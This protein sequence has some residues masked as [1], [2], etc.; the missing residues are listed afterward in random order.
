MMVWTEG[1]EAEEDLCN[2]L[3]MG[4][5]DEKRDSHTVLLPS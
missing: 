5:R 1:G 4:S 2:N 3:V